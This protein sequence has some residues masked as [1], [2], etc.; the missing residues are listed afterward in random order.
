MEVDEGVEA[1]PERIEACFECPPS[2]SSSSSS[3]KDGGSLVAKMVSMDVNETH[4]VTGCEDGRIIVWDLE[5]RGLVCELQGEHTSAVRHVVWGTSGQY[6][7]AAHDTGV[8]VCWD[9]WDRKCLCQKDGFVGVRNLCL[10]VGWKGGVM[11]CII[12]SVAGLQCILVTHAGRK[13]TWCLRATPFHKAAGLSKPLSL[14]ASVQQQ[15]DDNGKP[16]ERGGIEQYLVV[17]KTDGRPVSESSNVLQVYSN[18]SYIALYLKKTGGLEVYKASNAARVG[19]YVLKEGTHVSDI[20]FTPLDGTSQ[21][22][23]SSPSFAVVSCAQEYILVLDLNVETDN[24]TVACTFDFSSEGNS[25]SKTRRH[26]WEC[27]CVS[28]R[29]G[30]IYS[31]MAMHGDAHQC[32]MSWN[33]LASRAENLLKGP[34][35]KPVSMKCHPDPRPTQLF[36]LCDDGKVYVWCSIMS[37]R[38]SIFQPEFETLEYNREYQET[39]NEFDEDVDV[40]LVGEEHKRGHQLLYD[41]DDAD[42]T[43]DVT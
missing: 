18:E 36:V 42:A 5:S 4:L 30:F 29:G 13:T 21:K 41:I 8:L 28:P 6:V 14:E 16:A 38:W 2:S 35:G 27:S 20:S 32:I 15:R 19:Q 22:E 3:P 12:S 37:Q 9:V 1:V 10:W 26:S 39:E 24:L 25:D 11:R 40:E 33:R 43:I 23:E 7:V 31:G 34:Q 17:Q